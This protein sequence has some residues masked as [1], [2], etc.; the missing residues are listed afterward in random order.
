M[1]FPATP[2]VTLSANDVALIVDQGGQSIRVAAY[3]SEGKCLFNDAKALQLQQSSQLTSPLHR[4]PNHQADTHSATYNSDQL[5]VIVDQLL[6]KAQHACQQQSLHVTSIGLCSQGSSIMAWNAANRR[7]ISP[8]IS[9]QDTRGHSLCS[10]LASQ[11]R[12]IQ[13]MS[14][15]PLSPHYAASKIGLLAP[16]WLSQC[17]Y[18]DVGSVCRFL[19]SHLCKTNNLPQDMSHAQRW[20]LLDIQRQTWSEDLIDL[21]RLTDFTEL[22][23]SLAPPL[24]HWGDWQGSTIPIMLCQRDQAC[25]LFAHGAPQADSVYI[26]IGTGAFMQRIS[27]H[28]IP[29]AHWLSSWIDHWQGKPLYAIEACVNGAAAALPWL[30]TVLGSALTVEQAQTLTLDS[31]YWDDTPTLLNACGGLGSPWW[32]SQ[33]NSQFFPQ[34][35]EPLSALRGWLDSIAFMLAENHHELNSL[36]SPPKVAVVSGGLSQNDYLLQVLAETL[37]IP[38]KR[39]TDTE[40]SAKGAAYLCHYGLAD[41]AD[42]APQAWCIESPSAVFYPSDKAYAVEQRYQRWRTHMPTVATF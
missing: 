26:N 2:P 40:S 32:N 41:N 22:L 18:A 12:F 31:V 25:A 17:D 37:Q 33:L 20:Q 11:S 13:T 4:Q 10:T 16:E 28:A 7:P 39:Y 9:W 3:N 21:F 38:V 34:P 35:D 30:E 15:L 27:Q 6:G 14:G 8:V 36:L 1:T 5:T 42:T 24:Q 19:C 23:P 29:S